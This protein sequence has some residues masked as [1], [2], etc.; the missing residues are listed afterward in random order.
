[1]VP[2][3]DSIYGYEKE[4]RRGAVLN[5][6]KL[7]GDLY[8]W[9]K[10]I[11]LLQKK[12]NNQLSVNVDLGERAKGTI[13]GLQD[14]LKRSMIFITVMIQCLHGGFHSPTR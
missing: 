10:Q 12:L 13:N 9:S 6:Q 11:Q 8:S 3:A 1:M 2:F 14:A 5:A 4:R 7:A